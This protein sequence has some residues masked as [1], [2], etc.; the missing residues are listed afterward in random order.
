[1]SMHTT[2]TPQHSTRCEHCDDSVP[3]EHLDVRA[4]V[5][6][7]ADRARTRA[8]RMLAVAGGLAVVTAVVGVTIAGP[9]R[10]F[11]ALGVAVLGW[12]L[13]TAVAVAAVGV[14]RARTSDARALVLAAL[15]SAG[16]APLVALA[17]AALGG[18]WSGALV[19]GSA[20]LLCG[21]VADVV[22]SRTWRR[23]LL[24]PGEAGEHARARAVA[25][26]DS[27][28]D[29]TRWLAQGVLVGA[30]TWL[31]GVLPLAV[32]VLVPLAVALAAVTARPVAR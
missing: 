1:M 23:L 24:T 12:L 25:E 16:L 9:G 7:S 10:A 26:R 21:A 5:T 27:S 15:V 18:G 2:E 3:H 8:L 22:R 31:L 29:L 6:R 17:V 19:A 28:R 32:V 14:G 30:S 13:V 11:G 4:L 20:W